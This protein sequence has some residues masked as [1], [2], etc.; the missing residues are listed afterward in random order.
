LIR[1]DE[2]FGVFFLDM[3]AVTR[4]NLH[5]KVPLNIHISNLRS[6]SVASLRGKKFMK[7]CK[8]G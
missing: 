5:N 4:V 1:G 7:I 8:L 6:M 3:D 2:T